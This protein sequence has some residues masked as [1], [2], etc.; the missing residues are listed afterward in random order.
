MSAEL[1]NRVKVAI[2]MLACFVGLLFSNYTLLSLAVGLVFTIIVFE[3]ISMY[4]YDNVVKYLGSALFAFLYLI[5]NFDIYLF[6]NL[7]NIKYY[8]VFFITL[9]FANF[10]LMYF[11]NNKLNNLFSVIYIF[12][13]GL[14]ISDLMYYINYYSNFNGVTLFIVFLFFV[15][16]ITDIFAYFVG[17]KFGK[18]KL[19]PTISPNKTIEGFFGGIFASVIFSSLFFYL[20]E[21]S[22]L[23]ALYENILMDVYLNYDVSFFSVFLILVIFLSISSQLG[24]LYESSLK[25]FVGIK[26]S[27]KLLGA[28][29]GF[30]DRFDGFVSVIVLLGLIVNILI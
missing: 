8:Y 12:S 25:R 19:C 6:V 20:S 15:V 13:A 26:D 23:M 14:F 28:H 10:T 24:D 22:S 21:Q 11:K 18:H 3:T 9:L 29:G 5:F 30:F 4:K 2:I 7:V 17:K 16:S 27:G 1:I